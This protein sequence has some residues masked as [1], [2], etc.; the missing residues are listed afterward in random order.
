VEQDGQ[1]A[2]AVDT[3][4]P[5][6]QRVVTLGLISVAPTDTDRQSRLMKMVSTYAGLLIDLIRYA[7]F[8]QLLDHLAVEKCR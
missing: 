2:V 5:V 3:E 6:R 7:E 1:Y 4:P 8:S